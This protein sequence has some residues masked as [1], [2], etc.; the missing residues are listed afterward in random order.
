MYQS[1]IVFSCLE[2]VCKVPRDPPNS[3]EKSKGFKFLT[4]PKTN[5]F[6]PEN[7]WLD[8]D[9]F[10]VGAGL[11]SGGKLLVSGRVIYNAQ[12][13]RLLGCPRKL[14]NGLQPTYKWGILEL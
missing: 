2:D 8:D 11:F 1:L 3:H 7:G 10:L 9:P 14:A 12:E 5:I 13:K 4:L 6:A